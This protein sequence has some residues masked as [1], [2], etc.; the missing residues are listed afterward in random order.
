MTR[1]EIVGIIFTII[2]WLFLPRTVSS[3]VI[4]MLLGGS[5]W[6]LFGPLAIIGLVI[7]CLVAKE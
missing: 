7:D 4:G 1:L 3:L 2:I 6:W 5:W